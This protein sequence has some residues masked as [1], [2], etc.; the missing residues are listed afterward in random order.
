MGLV[1]VLL[2]HRL[3]RAATGAFQRVAGRHIEDVF[4]GPSESR[5]RADAGYLLLVQPVAA[6]RRDGDR[7]L[8]L[9]PGASPGDGGPWAVDDQQRPIS[10]DPAGR[11][12]IGAGTDRP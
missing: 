11:I 6:V 1:L 9:A 3:R 7:G 12:Q 2:V 8:A 10:G 4:P 5:G